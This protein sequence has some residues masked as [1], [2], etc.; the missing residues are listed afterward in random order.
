MLQHTYT[1]ITIIKDMERLCLTVG[2][3]LKLI[4]EWN[5][6][7]KEKNAD[8]RTNRNIP[9]IYIYVCG[10]LVPLTDM[11]V[12]GFIFCYQMLHFIYASQ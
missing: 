2:N 5:F 6:L 4:I 12:Y 3:R 7:G 9:K 1:K 10:C 11:A 8:E